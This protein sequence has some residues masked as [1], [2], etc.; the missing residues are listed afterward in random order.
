MKAASDGAN[1]RG[2][3]WHAYRVPQSSRGD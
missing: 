2:R 3:L 1:G